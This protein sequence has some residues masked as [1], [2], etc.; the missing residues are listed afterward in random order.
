LLGVALSSGFRSLKRFTFFAFSAQELD[1]LCVRRRVVFPEQQAHAL[2]GSGGFT[3]TLG[4]LVR[5]NYPS[6]G[7]D[8]EDFIIVRGERAAA[9]AALF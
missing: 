7:S 8:G 9:N 1:L 2:N 5:I 3:I 4:A 6:E